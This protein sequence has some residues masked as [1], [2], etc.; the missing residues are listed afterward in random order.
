M[1]IEAEVSKRV[2]QMR[3]L[4]EEFSNGRFEEMNDLYSDDFKGWLYIPSKNKVELYNAEQIKQGNK[5]AAKSYQ[6]KEIK[7]IYSGLKI[8]PQ[9]DVQAAVSYEIIHQYKEKIVRAL[10]LEVWR[11]ELDGNWRMIRWYEEKG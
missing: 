9:S 6:G 1:S 7:F 8:I 2:Y 5:E 4:H 11:K 3:K 10:S